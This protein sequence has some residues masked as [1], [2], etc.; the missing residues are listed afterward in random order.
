MSDIEKAKKIAAVFAIDVIFLLNS[1]QLTRGKELD[2]LFIHALE[3]EK[4]LKGHTLHSQTNS[5]DIIKYILYVIIIIIICSVISC[6][7]YFLTN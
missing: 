1:E 3:I 7:I 2:N 5:W 4:N 6:S